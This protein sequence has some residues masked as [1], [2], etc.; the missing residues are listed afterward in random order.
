MLIQVAASLLLLLTALL[1]KLA[2]QRASI[3]NVI[4]IG[5]GLVSVG[6]TA[7]EIAKGERGPTTAHFD[8]VSVAAALVATVTCLVVAFLHFN[9]RHD[10]TGPSSVQLS[11]TFWSAGL[12]SLIGVGLHPAL[13]WATFQLSVAALLFYGRDRSQTFAK[14]WKQHS[15]LLVGSALLGIGTILHLSHR[16]DA[17]WS[18]TGMVLIIC[19][20]GGALRWFPFPRVIARQES[21][22]PILDVIALRFLPSMTAAVFL[23]R[24]AEQVPFIRQQAFILVIASLF[25]LTICTTR[26]YREEVFSRRMTFLSFSTLS[27]LIVALCIQN[28]QWGH[29]DDRNW[30]ISSN[31]PTGQ[32]LFVLILL[33]ES[34]T[35]LLF[36]CSHRLFLSSGNGNDVIAPLTGAVYQRPIASI[37]LVAALANLSGLPPFPGFWWRLGLIV[38]CLL[39]HHQSGLTKMIEGDNGFTLLA[40]VLLTI[41]ILQSL[42][43]LKLIQHVLLEQPF[44]VREMPFKLVTSIATVLMLVCLL[45]LSFCPVSVS[46]YLMDPNADL[47][48]SLSQRSES[49]DAR[50]H[51][52]T[53]AINMNSD[54]SRSSGPVQSLSN[55]DF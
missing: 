54:V 15:T 26:I 48:T 45:A 47:Q 5:V 32:S 16:P 4:A 50:Q 13:T 22:E 9:S 18:S 21:Q 30:S 20:L 39:P 8:N 34:T 52:F 24:L 51:D 35:L 41:L 19:G 1:I 40:V 31:L 17:T 28:W 10:K 33:S 29:F 7:F 3:V 49:R 42:G 53:S 43:N 25:T 27:A 6:L 14:Y 36:V 23:W 44:R 2:G 37:P 11:A 38:A 55:M 12:L 46:R